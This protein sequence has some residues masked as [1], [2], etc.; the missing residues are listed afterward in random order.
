MFYYFGIFLR[1]YHYTFRT[2]KIKKI[3]GTLD[4]CIVVTNGPSFKSNIKD[5]IE[6]IKTKTIF[7]VN[8]FAV[9][10]YFEILKPSFHVFTDPLYWDKNVQKYIID[11][12]NSNIDKYS[13]V[14]KNYLSSVMENNEVAFN[15]LLN[16]TEWELYLFVPLQSKPSGVFENAFISNKNIKICYYIMT[17]INFNIPFLRHFLYKLNLGMPTPMTVAVTAIFLALNLN[18][19]KIYLMGMDHSFHEDIVVN[20]KNILCTKD[21]HFYCD[22]PAVINPVLVKNIDTGETL[23][24]HEYFYCLHIMFRSHQL[25]KIYAN[26]I[27]AKIL[28]MSSKSYIDAYERFKL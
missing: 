4:E 23:K 10:E 9:S 12:K 28:N 1:Y 14:A 19:K 2:H 18:F 22:N 3:I 7:S 26:S 17:P 5:D 8:S 20:E 24:I 16:K 15:A 21:R 25:L 11:F 6:F 13:L 27:G